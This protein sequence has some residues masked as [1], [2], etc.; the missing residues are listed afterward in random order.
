M[1]KLYLL[2]LFTFC[3]SLIRAYIYRVPDKIFLQGKMYELND[4]P[5]YHD[6]VNVS[7]L[8]SYLNKNIKHGNSYDDVCYWSVKDSMLVLDSIVVSETNNRQKSLWKVPNLEE[9][10]L[11]YTHNNRIEATWL[12]T[13]L[14]IFE[15][16]PVEILGDAVRHTTGE[17]YISVMEGK[18]LGVKKLHNKL[19]HGMSLNDIL[20]R[21]TVERVFPL[22]LFK[23]LDGHKFGF[24]ARLGRMQSGMLQDMQIRFRQL[25]KKEI[26][27]TVIR[28]VEEM[29]HKTMLAQYPMMSAWIN[30]TLRYV[31][32]CWNVAV[33]YTKN[34]F[35]PIY[36]VCETMPEFPGGNGAMFKFIAEHLQFPPEAAES[37]IQGRVILSFVVE[38]DGRIS[39]IGIE[40]SVDPCLDREAIKVLKQFPKFSPAM[41]VGQSVRC[42]YRLPISFRLL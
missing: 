10:L 25:D 8:R 34:P 20:K 39:C 36:T 19:Y 41:K 42:L 30:S 22:G 17:I 28:E 2:L 26:D 38:T 5:L 1:K 6:R 35:Q 40:R 12:N 24:S 21:D 4:R 33:D 11:V 3:F 32:G 14:S 31:G 27:T 13:T 29:L 16:E 15:G 7:V 37:N 23:Q 18:I 9:L